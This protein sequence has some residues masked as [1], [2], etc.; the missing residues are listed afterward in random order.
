MATTTQAR[1]NTARRSCWT[2]WGSRWRSEFAPLRV[3]FLP[4]GEGGARSA[5]DERFL[6]QPVSAQ[7]L[8]RP[9]CGH[10]LPL[11][12]GFEMTSSPHGAFHG[13]HQLLQ[14]ERLRQESEVLAFGQILR[15]R[16]FRV[17]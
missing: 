17:A 16:V 9:R 1:A 14:R 6:S 2:R 12:E 15:K 3:F 4:E 8:T 7:P 5:T 13:F 10:P 11:G